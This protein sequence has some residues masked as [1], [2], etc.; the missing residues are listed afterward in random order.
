MAFVADEVLFL[1]SLVPLEG[2]HVAELGCGKADFA[3]AL[4]ARAGVVRVDA[5]EVDRIQ[6]AKN[7][8]SAP[9]EKL[10]FHLGGAE[11]IALPDASIDGVVMMKSLHHVPM[12]HLDGALAEIRRV[13][14]PGGWLYVSEPV[15]AGE[16]N[17]I[18]KLFHD[19]GEVRAAAQAAVLR[20]AK[21]K[22]LD[23]EV[24]REFMAPL[25]FRDFADFE[26]K[27]IGATHSSH[28][29]TPERLGEVRRRFEAHVTPDG[30]KFTRPMRV[31]LMRRALPG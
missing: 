14:K 5:F 17:E 6:H 30:A 9:N 16:F 2:A 4:I 8:A 22:V 24:D 26:T 12:E 18:V 13:L 3:R 29:L 1:Q 11:A 7:L 10:A 31:Q 25:A 21:A 19:E 28:V 20:A 15:Y 27:V 23:L